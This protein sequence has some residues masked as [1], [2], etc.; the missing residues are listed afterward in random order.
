[1]GCDSRDERS[2]PQRELV[3]TGTTERSPAPSTTG[4]GAHPARKRERPAVTARAY[5]DALN[6]RDGDRLCSLLARGS[7]RQ[8]TL[9]RKQFGCARA[10]TASI[11]QPG[12]HGEPRW[13]G[14]RL[15]KVGAVDRTG[16]IV[17][18][19]ISLRHRFAGT[20]GEVPVEQDVVYLQ[21]AGRHWLIAKP[22]AVLYR[23]VGIGDVPT[24]ALE[25]PSPE[26]AG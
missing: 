26:P 11:G 10:L 20:T 5:I 24:E 18:V 15:V 22:S 14:S 9:Q 16:R 1:L 8:L 7:W 4:N 2:A 6:A 19:T 12:P 21:P 17:R 23:A 3:Q 13:L 25:P